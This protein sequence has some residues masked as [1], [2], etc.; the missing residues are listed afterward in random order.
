MPKDKIPVRPARAAEAV[1][2]A[3]L[4]NT[5]YGRT[6]KQA[7]WTSEGHLIEGPRISIEQMRERI[8]EPDSVVLVADDE[9]SLVGCVHLDQA[10]GDVCEVGMLSVHV[11]A[12]GRGL[13]GRLLSAAEAYARDEMRVERVV[14]FVLTVR[15]ELFPWYERRGYEATG[16]REPLILDG[17]QRSRVGPLVF[18][19]L[20]K[21]LA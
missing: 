5:A 20:E 4:V 7:G 11:D 18:E 15:E 12:Q 19:V 3:K 9:G 2:L 13:G 16:E 17:D 10:G 8:Q 14:L 6:P 21:K 1:H